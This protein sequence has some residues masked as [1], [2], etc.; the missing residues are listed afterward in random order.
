MGEV[1]NPELAGSVCSEPALRVI[2]WTECSTVS[3]S[4]DELLPASD[5]QQTLLAHETFDSAT[6]DDDAFSFRQSSDLTGSA[7]PGTEL[8]IPEHPLDLHDQ[9]HVAQRASWWRAPRE[10]IVLRRGD[11][12]TVLGEHPADRLDPEPVTMI[13]NEL[14]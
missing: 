8:A 9:F 10:R 11:P 6:R 4:R 3:L 2:G 7:D 14:N 12:H 5:A 1:D 13:I